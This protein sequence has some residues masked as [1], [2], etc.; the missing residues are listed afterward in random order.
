MRTTSD[1]PVSR[2]V[3]ELDL[4]R[5]VALIAV[6]VI[7]CGAWVAPADTPAYEG[8]MAGI[9]G[10]AR[11]S[12]PAFV[13]LSGIVLGRSQR[14]NPD[15]L[16]FLHKRTARVLVPWAC[17]I[18][19]FAFIAWRAGAV[20][21]F[22]SLVGWALSGPGHLYFLV[23]MAQLY[24]VFLVLPVSQRG[25][26]MFTCL[27]MAA[28]LGLMWLHTYGPDMS[29]PV[30]WPLDAMAQE[31][32]PFWLGFFALGCLMGRELDA[33]RG[34]SRL[35][36]L[37][38]VS[39]LFSCGLYFWESTRVPSGVWRQG[40]G[41]FL[42]PSMVPLTVS[43]VLTIMWL[44]LRWEGPW[45]PLRP[46]VK[47]LSDQSLGVYIAHPA[48]LVVLGP[49]TGGL[50]ALW[51]FLVLLVGTLTISTAL[52]VLAV[53]TCVGSWALS[54]R[55]RNYPRP[56]RLTILPIRGAIEQRVRRASYAGTDT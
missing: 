49:L 43:M 7:H 56:A 4:V 21:D 1:Y 33:I 2:R 5:A 40:A 9:I 20:H 17:A 10:L 47:L 55:P 52:V 46:V 45:A 32:F 19:L 39:T 50:P 18:P 44:G 29:G 24:M 12:V 3:A 28:Q 41:S 54:G 27:A 14:R 8:L 26:A 25:L 53:R 15:T 31:E 35:W 38:L 23:L 42:W 16:A 36:P 34:W 51:R 30:Q 48:V 6:L 11:F 22:T 13:L 37:A